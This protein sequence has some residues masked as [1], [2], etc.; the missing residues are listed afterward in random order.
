MPQRDDAM[1]RLLVSAGFLAIGAA[2]GIGANDVANAFAT[3]VGSGALTVKQAICMGAIL[4]PLGAV[5]L[6]TQRRLERVESC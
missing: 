4:E 3:S 5:M 1:H 6:G 2:W